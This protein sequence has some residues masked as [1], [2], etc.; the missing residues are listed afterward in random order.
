MTDWDV[1][2]G[3]H[4]STTFAKSS[5]YHLTQFIGL[6]DKR[7][8]EVYEGDVL[9]AGA[10]MHGD[11]F[12]V[13]RCLPLTR[14]AWSYIERVG[15]WQGKKYHPLGTKHT[16]VDISYDDILSFPEECEVIGNIYENPELIER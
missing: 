5:N 7:G 11:A 6:K 10:A 1:L 9:R 16:Q 12:L 8:R 13:R 14:M 3:V 4:V 2:P 15:F